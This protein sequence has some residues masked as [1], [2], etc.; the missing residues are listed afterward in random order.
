ML[1]EYTLFKYTKLQ[2]FPELQE[3]PEL[4]K[5]PKEGIKY[6][7][8]NKKEVEAIIGDAALETEIAKKKEAVKK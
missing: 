3:L 4:Q 1:I 7:L 2:E 6:Q 8:I 5:F